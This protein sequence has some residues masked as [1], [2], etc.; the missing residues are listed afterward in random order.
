M[1]EI[2]EIEIEGDEFRNKGE[3]FSIIRFFAS[4]RAFSRLTFLATELI[5]KR[6]SKIRLYIFILGYI[7]VF[8]VFQIYIKITCFAI[9]NQRAVGENQFSVGGRIL[10]KSTVDSRKSHIA[11]QKDLI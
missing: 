3:A 4:C 7:N 9:A 6:R 5:E 1:I 8:H 11:S 10:A 2:F